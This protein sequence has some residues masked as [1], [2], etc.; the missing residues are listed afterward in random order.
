MTEND[1][2]QKKRWKQ[3][4]KHKKNSAVCFAE[5]LNHVCGFLSSGG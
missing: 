1:A 3:N 5:R 4:S 2:A